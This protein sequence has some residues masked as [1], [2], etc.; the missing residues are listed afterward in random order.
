LSISFGD[1]TEV[2]ITAGA[3]VVSLSVVIASAGITCL[4]FTAVVTI[5]GFY[6]VLDFTHPI[7]N[8]FCL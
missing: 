7:A 4:L 1:A 2:I 6:L 5:N 3:P 8:R